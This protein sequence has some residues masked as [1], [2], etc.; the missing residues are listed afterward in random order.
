MNFFWLPDPEG[1]FFGEIFLRI[2]VL[3]FFLLITLD[4]ETIRN[5]KKVGFIFHPSFYVQ[6]DPGSCAFYP[7]DPDPG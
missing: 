6:W 3:L 2:F 7:Q 5:K 4:P 1:M